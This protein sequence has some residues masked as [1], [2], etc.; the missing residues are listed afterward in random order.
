M[1]LEN[2]LAAN[3]FVSVFPWIDQDHQIVFLQ[4]E[5][6]QNANCPISVFSSLGRRAGRYA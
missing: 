2:R 3:V 6:G 5:G 4:D 1:S